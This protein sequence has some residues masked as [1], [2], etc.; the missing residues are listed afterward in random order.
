VD[1]DAARKQAISYAAYNII[2]HR[3]V[4]GPAEWGRGEPPRWPTFASK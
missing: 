1:V 3:F 4:T 2:L